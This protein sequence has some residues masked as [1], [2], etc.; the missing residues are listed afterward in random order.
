MKAKNLFFGALACLAFAACS[1]DDEPV[2][3]PGGAQTE[4]DAVMAVRI[5]MPEAASTRAWADGDETK[6]NHVNGEAAEIAIS[7]VVLYFFDANGNQW[8][9]PQDITET[10]KEQTDGAD[11]TDKTI[12]SKCDAFV[13]FNNI[14]DKPSQ[15]IAVLNAKPLTDGGK[16]YK[17]YAATSI[18]ALRKELSDDFK[19]ITSG[20]FIMSNAVYKSD[21]NIVYAADCSNSL[22][23]GKTLADAQKAAKE[24]PVE[25]YVE[26]VLAR[27][28]VDMANSGGT[29]VTSNIGETQLGYNVNDKINIVAIPNGWWLDNTAQE[30]YLMKD[31][32][33]YTNTESWWNSED[34]KR[35]YWAKSYVGTSGDDKQWYASYDYSKY[36][37][38]LNDKYCF[39]NTTSEIADKTQLVVAATLYETESNG[40][41][42]TT[43][44]ILQLV[45]H[46]A[47]K[48][49]FSD[50]IKNIINTPVLKVK[51][52]G[53]DMRILTSEELKVVT[54]SGSTSNPTIDG[55]AI[56]AWQAKLEVNV[57]GTNIEYY[58]G[59]T[60]EKLTDKAAA[61]TLL[62]TEIGAFKY[63]K[64][65]QTYYFTDIQHYDSGTEQFGVVRNHMYKI[66]VT[67]ITGL[68]TPVPYDPNPTPTDPTDPTDPEDPKDPEYPTDP[69]D[70]TNPTDPEEPIDPEIPTNDQVTS[71]AAQIS[72]LQY[73]VVKQNVTL[74][75]THQ[76][77]K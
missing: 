21:D 43:Y 23:T 50:F 56:K 38:N 76:D 49:K 6:G 41:E 74:D 75:G 63:W 48:W 29:Y 30:S 28:S 37:N 51:V 24:A 72:V 52:D 26:R 35:S 12:E 69:E 15:V 60:N 5:S 36:K 67:S 34:Y 27:V 66:K 47:V 58:N 22:K 40:E 33:G 2:V 68:G 19:N 44:K 45:E 10:F 32:D 25:I 59:R 53:G 42:K 1:N 46:K 4:G 54:N 31:L 17:K 62:D 20:G 18:N 39:E 73:R 65:G 64:N 71:M 3:N 7:S 77:S 61:Q 9:E 13:I 11:A 70:P 57:S 55:K 8:G 14:Q 16:E